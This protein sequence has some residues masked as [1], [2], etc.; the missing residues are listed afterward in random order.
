M[1]L[2][3]KPKI[4]IYFFVFPVMKSVVFPVL[5]RFPVKLIC[6]I[7]FGLASSSC[8]LPKSIAMIILL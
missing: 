8:C 4:Y 5:F 1:V 6:Y 7:N 3:E 2:C